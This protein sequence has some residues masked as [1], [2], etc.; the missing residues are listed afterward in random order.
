[1]VFVQLDLEGL[2]VIAVLAVGFVLLL[3]GVYPSKSRENSL[4][5]IKHGFFSTIAT[6]ISLVTVLVI[7]VPFFL[8]ILSNTSTSSFSQFPIMWLHTILGAITMVSGF[9]MIIE[10]TRVPLNELG[11]SK[12]WRL[13]KPT[14][15]AWVMALA[16][17][18]II[19]ISG[20]R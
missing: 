11:C 18:A 14:L 17:G 19:H 13:M 7:M 5:L 3:I 9:I 15:L 10:W 8:K 16:L 2:A 6:A 4:N 12:R 1:M 20:L